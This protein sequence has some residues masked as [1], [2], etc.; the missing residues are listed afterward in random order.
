MGLTHYTLTIVQQVHCGVTVVTF[1]G[2][3]I[4]LNRLEFRFITTSTKHLLGVK[5]QDETVIEA[6]RSRRKTER[7]KPH[8]RRRKVY[9]PNN[10]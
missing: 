2:I 3:F 9:F 1:S 7:T 4:L 6:P 5:Q 8:K 10:L